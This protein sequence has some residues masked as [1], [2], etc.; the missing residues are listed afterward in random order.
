MK[1]RIRRAAAALA[2]G[3]LVSLPAANAETALKLNMVSVPD[4]FRTAHPDVTIT[5][6]SHYY[7]TTGEMTTEMLVGAFDADVFWLHS[8]DID[9]RSIMEKG[10]CLDLSG[11]EIIRNAIQNLYPAF[12]GQCV[13]DGKIYAVPIGSQLDFLTMNPDLTAD[14]GM[15]E[16]AIPD[17]FPAF[18]DFVE[19][20]NVHLQDDPGDI[21][22]M[23]MS[24]W[25]ESDFNRVGGYTYYLVEHLL[26]NHILQ[27]SYA[28]QP[29][30]F[31]EPEVVE[32]LKRCYQVGHE[33]DENDP[34]YTTNKSILDY[35]TF[36]DNDASR[37]LPLRLNEDQ[38][39]LMNVSLDLAAVNARTENPE[40]CIELLEDVVQGRL[41]S[42]YLFA[43]AGPVLNAKYDQDN[44]EW[45]ALIQETQTLL[46]D[47]D[48]DAADRYELEERLEIQQQNYQEF[49]TNDEFKYSVSPGKLAIYRSY[50]DYFYVP[51]PDIFTAEEVEQAKIFKQLKA[52]F[53]AGQITAEELAAE[54]DRIAQMIERE[55]E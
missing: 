10:Y 37:F 12:A 19:A 21:A 30:R 52:R 26:R 15:G 31:N 36:I 13:K 35:G 53:V 44:V 5:N 2:L 33:L 38:P 50:V 23:G 49:L 32:L 24:F 20:W 40:L 47:P 22:L 25:D 51:M 6:D 3:L 43:N 48:L 46:A 29:L 17:S 41:S 34:S 11:S 28:G 1:K 27:K 55:S 9:Y 42:P 45:Q 39:K 54:L 8:S 14:A 18:L 4:S 7:A 16:V